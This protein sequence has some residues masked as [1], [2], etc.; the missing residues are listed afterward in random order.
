MFS[1]C[2]GRPARIASTSCGTSLQGCDRSRVLVDTR[3]LDA[4]FPAIDFFERTGTPF[5]VAVN[6][7][8]GERPYSLDQVREALRV[9]QGVPMGYCD[10]RRRVDAQAILV[11]LVEHALATALAVHAT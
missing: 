5:L 10:A 11:K 4:C 2:L 9:P 3:R 8:D 7:F 1:I 6:T